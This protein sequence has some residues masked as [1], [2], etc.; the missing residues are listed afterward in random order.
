MLVLLSP[1]PWA[2]PTGADHGSSEKTFTTVTSWDGHEIPVTIYRP[3]L[4]DETNPVPVILHSHGWSGSR[5]KADDAFHAYAAAGFGVVSIDMRGHGDARQTSEARVHHVDYEIADVGKVI[6]YVATLPWVL[7]DAPGDPRLG[8]I[9]GS[10]GGAYQLLSA[11]LDGRLDALVPEI[12]WNSLPQSLAPNGVV[13]SAWVDV[14][15]AAGNALARVHPTIHEAYAYAMSTNELPDGSVPGTPDLIT[16]FT[17]SS[18]AIYPDAIDVPTLLIQG[19][20]DTLFNF[21]QAAANYLQIKATGAP[22]KL[23]THLGGHILNT[24]GTLDFAP[25][26]IDVGLQPASGPSPCGAPTALA[27][28]WF[29]RHLLDADVDTGPNVCI[30]LDD[31]GSL[32]AGSYPLPRRPLAL[33]SIGGFQLATGVPSVTNQ[34]TLLVAEHSTTIAGVPTI[35]GLVTSS[36]PDAVLFWSLVAVDGQTGETRTV[37][38]QVT[39]QRVA[40]PV[41][42][43]PFKLDL[44]GIGLR[45]KVGDRLDLVASTSSDQ[46]LHN[47]GRLLGLVTIEELEV[48]LPIVRG[49]TH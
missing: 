7:L 6:D 45:L 11:A 46:F 23:V 26:P 49:R 31:G 47:G 18:P 34:Q 24:N 16:Q 4:A 9:G 32:A 22:V 10:Y 39:P 29:Q 27:I 35:K 44:G 13:K 2:T 30:A 28:A 5:A 38:S 20:P 21:N 1:F 41:S 36:T 48:D 25:A 43:S 8:A 37:D 17:T 42:D 40:D 3:I 33:T 12:T 15:Y 19:M 14:L